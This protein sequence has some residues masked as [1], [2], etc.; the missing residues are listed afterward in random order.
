MRSIQKKVKKAVLIIAV[1]CAGITLAGSRCYTRNS[2]IVLSDS[3]SVETDEQKEAAAKFPMQLTSKD[4]I[5]SVRVPESWIE[6]DSDLIKCIEF[7]AKSTEEKLG[8]SYQVKYILKDVQDYENDKIN[9]M[10]LE[11]I[12]SKGNTYNY[13]D[14]KEAEVLNIDNKKAYKWEVEGKRSSISLK[15]YC[16]WITEGDYIYEVWI[17]GEDTVFDENKSLIEDIIK[18]FTLVK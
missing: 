9:K 16:I 18:T 4:G 6:D 7:K 2:Y 14:I 11:Q 15:M 5:F 1:L 10:F 17:G 3:V 12:K 13:S 8:M